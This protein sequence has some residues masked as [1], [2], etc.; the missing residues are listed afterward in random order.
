V[1]GRGISYSARRIRSTDSNL[2]QAVREVAGWA[3]ASR[4]RRETGL[5]PPDEVLSLPSNQHLVSPKRT[6]PKLGAGSFIEA[7][8]GS[9]F[10]VVYVENS[11]E[12]RDLQQVVDF[13]GKVQKLQLPALV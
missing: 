7:G 5:V 3:Y 11:Q 1:P 10:I 8:N 13:P 12:L 4:G 6:Y 9:G 2:S